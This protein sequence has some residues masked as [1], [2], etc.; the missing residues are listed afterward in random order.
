M[1]W[2]GLSRWQKIGLGLAVVVAALVVGIVIAAIVEPEETDGT[3]QVI[4]P[5]SMP[6]LAPTFASILTPTPVPTQSGFS[7]DALLLR[8]ALQELISIK[9]ET[10]FHVFCYAQRS[11]ANSWSNHI[12]SLSLS[13]YHETGIAPGDLWGMGWEYCQNE[14]R[15]TDDTRWILK[16]MKPDWVN[17][18]PVPTP[19]PELRID[20][21]RP[22]ASVSRDLAECAWNNP[23]M[24][25]VLGEALTESV[26]MEEYA[27][28]VEAALDGGTK[29]TWDGIITAITICE[30][31]N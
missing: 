3:V 26:T 10:W 23:Y 18:R 19:I 29:A 11:P 25:E 15:D 12:N 4:Q 6:A 24:A 1:W 9:H 2:K 27:F 13:A 17:H 5:T 30:Q 28:V 16:Q 20:A 22:F 14:G 8:A 7:E 31:T 21:N